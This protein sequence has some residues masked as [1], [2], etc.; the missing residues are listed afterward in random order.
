MT[1]YETAALAL[2]QMGISSRGRNRQP[3]EISR[4]QVQQTEVS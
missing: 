3:D 2:W 1:E 4:V